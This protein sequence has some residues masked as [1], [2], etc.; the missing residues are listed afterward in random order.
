MYQE[1]LYSIGEFATLCNTTK[2]TLNHYSQ[3]GL[4]E[5][6][7][8]ADNG[9]RQYTIREF[10]LFSMIRT[11]RSNG[12]SLDE[13]RTIIQTG[14]SH[15][16]IEFLEKHKQEYM[17]KRLELKE[18]I[19]ML[20]HC[21]RFMKRSTSIPSGV[22]MITVETDPIY[23]YTTQAIHPVHY[24]DADFKDLLFHH[25][26]ATTDH[27]DVIK[28]PVGAIIKQEDFLQDNYSFSCLV[29]RSTRPCSEEHGRTLHIGKYLSYLS[30]S[31]ERN[32][33]AAYALLHD[34]IREHHLTVCGDIFE[35]GI[36]GNLSMKREDVCLIHIKI[37]IK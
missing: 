8:I 12:C 37:P 24:N 36:I 4:L 18:S 21:I 32:T 31:K 17:K 34:Y 10:F 29:S 22:P 16:Y 13:I 6:A 5:P 1:K 3:I 28:Y 23:L 15:Q 9:Y 2:D 35:F 14:D 20:D 11:L 30:Q 27:K 33:D 26:M 25:L 7:E 19:Y